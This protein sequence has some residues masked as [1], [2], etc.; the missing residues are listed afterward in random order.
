MSRPSPL[1][2]LSAAVL[3][4]AH[5]WLAVSATVEKSPTYDEPLH[6]TAGYTYWTQGDFRL[7]PENGNLPQRWAALPLLLDRP[8]LPIEGLEAAWRTSDAPRIQTA[9]L[10]DV[11]NP[12]ERML[13]RARSAAV[14]WSVA[15]GLLLFAWARTLWGDAG[16]LLSLALFTVSA[17][18]LAHGPLVTSDMCAAFFFLAATGAFWR[19]LQRLTPGSLALSAV[20]TGLA[21]VAKFS[22]VLLPFVFLALMVWRLA[23][24]A[25]WSRSWGSAD[26]TIAARPRRAAWLGASVLVHLAIAWVT[27]WT[28]FDWRYLPAGTELPEMLQYYRLWSFT[29]P[30]EGLLRS[31]VDLARELRALPEA[32]IHGFTFVHA[33]SQE[34]S[35]FLNAEFSDTGW[36]WFFPYAFLVKTPLAELLALALV[37]TL[38]ALRWSRVD[39]SLRRA[40][41]LADLQRV[42]P[43]AALLA[44]YGAFSITS[45][46]NIGHRHLLPM[47]PA[48]L[49]LSGG[50][51]TV[52]AVRWRR[53]AAVVLL[54]L[55]SLESFAVRPHYLA[56]FNA[57]VGGPA[58]GWR[59]LVDSSLDW[60]Q[61]LPGLARWLAA[62]QAENEPAFVTVFGAR[63]LEH[64][65]IRATMLAPEF[66][67]HPRAWAELRG[68]I[69]AVSAT[70]LQNV[71]SPWRGQWNAQHEG[72]FQAM[73]RMMEPRLASDTASRLIE[74]A[75]PIG[76]N[77]N[78]YDRVRFARLSAYLRLRTPDAVIGHSIFVHRLSDEEAQTVARGDTQ[79]YL[80]LL[81]RAR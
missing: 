8:T 59:H 19:H 41:V 23:T 34:R 17:T 76:P 65:G 6:L 57:T 56:F 22:F 16:A 10:F 73:A 25:G 62:E 20:V 42:L 78:T 37:T 60:G 14:L 68:G 77:L 26:A 40:T 75:D 51:V 63:N 58:N 79:A 69:Y 43:L 31:A 33:A 28:F 29:L 3:L 47:Y 45:R 27:I 74:P 21:T 18:T 72:F 32:F 38:V 70:M 7:Q 80:E 48:L 64:Y 54:L 9:F 53:I 55:A 35:A 30:P 49:I 36:W 67:L 39:P 61:D 15:L 1:V 52:G 66:E 4:V 46:L 71:Y 50:L 81:E 5:A 44:V 12:T 24:P 13:Q 2:L 11:G